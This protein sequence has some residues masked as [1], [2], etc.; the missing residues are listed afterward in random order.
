MEFIAF[1]AAVIAL[2]FIVLAGFMI[3][4]LIEIKKTAVS[5]RT[6]ITDVQSQLQPILKEFNELTANLRLVTGALSSRTGEVKAFMDALGDT[7]RNISTINIVVG[8]AATLLCRSS[9]WLKGLK[10]A[11]KYT[12]GRILKKEVI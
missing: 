9:L 1:A 2:T 11:S 4:A 6:Y 5:I 7:G 10:A 8:E 12:V 3:S